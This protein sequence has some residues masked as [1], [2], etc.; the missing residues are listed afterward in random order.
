MKLKD[1][2]LVITGVMESGSIPN[3]IG[4]P[5]TG[6]TQHVTALAQE[7][8]GIEPIV[9]LMHAGEAA[10]VNGLPFLEDYNE[11]TVA[12]QALPRWVL[13][14]HEAATHGKGVMVLFDEISSASPEHQAAAQSMLQDRTFPNTDYKFP[15]NVYFV[16]AMNAA[17]DA[18]NGS[19]LSAPLSN[20]LFH[21]D[22]NY[23]T[24]E[25]ISDFR[26]KWGSKTLSTHEAYVREVLASFLK[27]NPNMAYRLPESESDRSRPY[28]SYRTWDQLANNLANEKFQEAF[29]NPGDVF[30]TIVRGFLG[31]EVPAPLMKF[32]A[33]NSTPTV[34]TAVRD[35]AKID[36]HAD[37]FTMDSLNALVSGIIETYTTTDAKGKEYSRKAC[38]KAADALYRI[39]D[40]RPALAITAMQGASRIL[41]NT[42]YLGADKFQAL[43][44]EAFAEFDRQRVVSIAAQRKMTENS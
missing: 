43:Y 38:E 10:D 42:S 20:R 39:G 29:K 25:F 30:A 16:T 28:P 26:T 37:R 40:A 22:W 15:S 32:I 17:E 7:W 35:S 21:L 36:W 44:P 5:G 8:L 6:K 4:K 9:V 19:L 18:T 1:Y 23:E 11:Q 34:A 33:D 14:A 13:K 41:K 24:S 3:L 12:G 27:E 2:D 31:D